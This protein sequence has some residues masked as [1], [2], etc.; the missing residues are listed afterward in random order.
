MR[1]IALM[2]ARTAYKPLGDNWLNIDS[3]LIDLF[4][5]EVTTLLAPLSKQVREQFVRASTPEKA[6][7]FAVLS[8][9]KLDQSLQSEPINRLVFRPSIHFLLKTPRGTKPAVIELIAQIKKQASLAKRP[10]EVT[11]PPGHVHEKTD[12]LRGSSLMSNVVSQKP[13]GF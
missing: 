13:K 4:K 7:L 3:L 1:A 8:D 12:E 10:E 9:L 11:C 5:L 2:C 6:D